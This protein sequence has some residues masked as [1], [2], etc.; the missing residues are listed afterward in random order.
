MRIESQKAQE[1]G[2][3]IQ[4]VQGQVVHIRALSKKL[5]RQLGIL[6]CKRVLPAGDEGVLRKS[7]AEAAGCVLH[8]GSSP[9]AMPR[10]PKKSRT[11][12][13][14]YFVLI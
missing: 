12:R 13:D 9:G 11:Q 14:I 7:Q 4:H 1:A 5:V 3:T 6:V 8:H 2:E 10:G